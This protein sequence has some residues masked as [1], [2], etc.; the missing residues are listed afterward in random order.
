[1][2]GEAQQPTCRFALTCEKETSF[3]K[4]IN[5][6]ASVPC[7]KLLVIIVNLKLTFQRKYHLKKI[8]P[9]G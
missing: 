3:I 9:S 6:L 2:D 4:G 1:M 7:V 5:T 8:K